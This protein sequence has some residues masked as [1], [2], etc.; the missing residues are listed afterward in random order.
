MARH[1]TPNDRDCIVQ[2][3]NQGATRKEIAQKLRRH[4][5]TIGREIARNGMD[6]D[7]RAA[8]AP[9]RAERRRRE[10]PLQRKMD[11]PAVNQAVRSGLAHQWSPEQIA[12]RLRRDG[13]GRVSPQTIYTWIK[14]DPHRKHW[15]S[16]LRRRGKRPYRRKNA[17]IGCP[18]RGPAGNHRAA[19]AAG[20]FRGRH[21]A[22]PAADRRPGD[23]GGSQIAVHDCRQSSIQGRRP[24]A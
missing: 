18:H 17:A 12:G 22:R 15:E 13:C 5:S 6:G 3:L 9:W 10:R 16:F 11:D 1:L 23:A 24:R 2:C 20:R 19:V 4:P 8:A 21:G 7:Y 14:V